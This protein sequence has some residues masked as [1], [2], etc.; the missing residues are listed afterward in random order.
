[1]SELT[2]AALR[3][4]RHTAGTRRSL[5][6]VRSQLAELTVLASQIDPEH[7]T[8]LSYAEVKEA[9]ALLSRA[10][11][12]LQRARRSTTHEATQRATAEAIGLAVG[13]VHCEDEAPGD[14]TSADAVIAGWVDNGHPG[15][16]SW[17]CPNCI[18][19]TAVVA[20]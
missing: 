12:K 18:T 10:V 2:P 20:Q 13:C 19:S 14:G 11:T 3:A 1:M 17:C 8:G 5:N 4:Q 9:H 7:G 15:A 16:P 6:I